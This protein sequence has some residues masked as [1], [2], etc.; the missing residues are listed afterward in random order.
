MTRPGSSPS[1]GTDSSN[2]TK[3]KKERCSLSP[4]GGQKVILLPCKSAPS[5]ERV[6]LWLQAKRQFECLQRDRKR[7]LCAQNVM[8]VQDKNKSPHHEEVGSFLPLSQRQ[9]EVSEKVSALQTLRKNK[10]TLL[11][12]TSPVEAGISNSSPKEVKC[13]M[14]DETGGQV[15]GDG[16]SFMQTQSPD[17]SYLPP[18]QQMSDNKNLELS[19]G[20]VSP[21]LGSS[22]DPLSPENIKPK[23]FLSPS[24]FPTRDHDGESSSPSLLHSTPILSKRRNKGVHELDCSPGSEGSHFEMVYHELELLSTPA[25]VTNYLIYIIVSNHI[26]SN[27]FSRCGA[28]ISETPAKTNQQHECVT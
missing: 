22:I 12:G 19:V 2:L 15:E 26:W 13:A 24:P 17:P 21:T 4:T 14:E 23:Q 3:D 1:R 28:K 18:W 20:P 11:L 27:P 10:L 6:Q 9:G 8:S 16:N 7:R 5:R 25:N